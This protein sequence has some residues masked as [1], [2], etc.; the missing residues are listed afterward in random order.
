MKNACSQAATMPGETFL[1]FNARVVPLAVLI[2][3]LVVSTLRAMGGIMFSGLGPV[4]EVRPYSGY[5]IGSAIVAGIFYFC[6]L[7]G[8]VIDRIRWARGQKP[9]TSRDL[10]FRRLNRQIMPWI[11]A[12]FIFHALLAVTWG[13]PD[14]G[15]PLWPVLWVAFFTISFFTSVLI[16]L[17]PVMEWLSHRVYRVIARKLLP[18]H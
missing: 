6:L 12:V 10:S 3:V 11:F 17:V 8:W 13:L 16:Y 9:K 14:G 18:A 2:G 5:L 1:A 15:V 4:D 7:L